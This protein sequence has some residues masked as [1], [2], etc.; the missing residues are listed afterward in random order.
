MSYEI[1]NDWVRLHNMESE[2]PSVTEEDLREF[3]ETLIAARI[4][5]AKWFIEWLDELRDKL[6]DIHGTS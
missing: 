2:A 4:Q 3:E 6:K 5:G 1:H